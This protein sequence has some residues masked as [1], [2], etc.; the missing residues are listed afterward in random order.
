[1]EGTQEVKKGELSIVAASSDLGAKL[2]HWSQGMMPAGWV[3]NP[4]TDRVRN[5]LNALERSG[6][7]CP[8]VPER[9]YDTL[10]RCLYFREGKGCHCGLYIEDK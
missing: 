9:E 10:C 5:I 7:Y 1:M 3:L 8:C 4:D 6:G 2:S